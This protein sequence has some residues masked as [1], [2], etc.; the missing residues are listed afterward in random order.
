MRPQSSNSH[1]C[2]AAHSQDASSHALPSVPGAAAA[3]LDNDGG[4]AGEA[5]EALLVGGNAGDMV[6]AATAPGRYHVWNKATGKKADHRS[7]ELRFS[8]EHILIW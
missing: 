8:H 5:V 1:V 3:P 6:L 7:H 4:H 2:F